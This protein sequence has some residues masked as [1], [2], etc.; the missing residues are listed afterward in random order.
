MTEM[1]YG[2]YKKDDVSITLRSNSGTC[3]GG[4][5]VLII[6]NSSGNDIA[7]TLDSSYYKGQGL[8]EGIEREYVAIIQKTLEEK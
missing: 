2:D 8:R 3:G 5:E 6:Y 1:H 4:S 7:G